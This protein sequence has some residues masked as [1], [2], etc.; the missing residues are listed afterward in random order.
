MKQIIYK[1]DYTFKKEL[2]IIKMLC[3]ETG[4]ISYK[5]GENICN[6]YD[7]ESVSKIH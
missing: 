6:L 3:K 5:L 1:C 4:N 2:L 7:Q